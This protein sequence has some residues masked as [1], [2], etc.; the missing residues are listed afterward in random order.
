M[1]VDGCDAQDTKSKQPMLTKRICILIMVCLSSICV[2]LWIIFCAICKK[3]FEICGSS[4]SA[5]AQVVEDGLK[6][7]VAV[8]AA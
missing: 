7:D 6:N 1:T 5:N 2:N 4:H 3:I 8:F